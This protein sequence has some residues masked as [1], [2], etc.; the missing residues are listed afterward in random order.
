MTNEW[1]QVNEKPAKG[2][3]GYTVGGEYS[4]SVPG[5]DALVYVRFDDGSFAQVYHRGRVAPVPDLPVEVGLDGTG[6]LV[7]VGGDPARPG[8]VAGAAGAYEVGLHS[9]ARGSGMEFPVDARLLTP[10][11]ASPDGGLVVRVEQGAY[12]YGGALRWWGGGSITLTPPTSANQWAWIAVGIDPAAEALAVAS[13]SAVSIA[14][15]LEPSTIPA[16]GLMGMIPLAAVRVAQGQT[17]LDEA[18]FEDLRYP[19]GGAQTSFGIAGYALIRDEKT[20]NTDGGTFTSGAWQ[21]RDLNIKAADADNFVTLSSNQITLAAGTYRLQA[22]AP[23]YEVG[24]HQVRWQNVSDGV[25]V[26]VGT[27]ENSAGA[28]TR[29]LIAARFTISASETFELQQQGFATRSTDGLGVAAGFGTE[30]YAQVEL[31]RE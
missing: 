7:I 11:R 5:N 31:W 23:A 6:N 10:V 25:T 2:R 20:V 18:D 4:V 30:V 17:E 26:A 29:S 16:I 12:W 27:A 8:A 3:L 15:P 22:S 9:H 24:S 1:G 13:G 19:V 28:Q 21:T 14:A